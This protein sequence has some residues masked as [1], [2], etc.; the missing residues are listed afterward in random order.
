MTVG[1]GPEAQPANVS[2]YAAPS[3]DSVRRRAGQGSF[4]A[5]FMTHAVIER[6]LNGAA[7]DRRGARTAKLAILCSSVAFGSRTGPTAVFSPGVRNAWR[8]P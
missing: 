6:Q 4:M 1:L 3:A 2:T 7:P 5:L 8:W